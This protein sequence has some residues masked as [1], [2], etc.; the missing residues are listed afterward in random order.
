MARFYANENFPRPAVEELRRLGHDVLTSSEAGQAGQA[1]DDE[2]V[3]AF[4]A[5]QGRILLTL[6]RRHFIALHGRRPGH[7]G[8]IACSLDLDFASLARRIHE[9]AG[10]GDLAGKLVRVNRPG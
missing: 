10:P 7:S 8:I 9:A 5:G 3:L 1:L 2:A 6:N 4:A